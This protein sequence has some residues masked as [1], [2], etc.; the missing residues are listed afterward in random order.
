MQKRLIFIVGLIVGLVLIG[1][2]VSSRRPTIQSNKLSVVASFYPIA[3][4]A[5]QVGGDKISVTNI[6]PASTEPHDFEP[7]ARDLIRI[8]QAKLFI[9]NG[10]NVDSWGDK[11][12]SDIVARGGTVIKMSDALTSLPSSE[13]SG[14]L[15]PH[16]WLD[17]ILAQQEITVIRDR[18]VK[19]DPTNAGTYQHNAQA[20]IDQLT[21]LDQSY[22]TGLANCQLHDIVTSHAAF[23]YLA[24]R[25]G[26]TQI[27][28]AGISPDQ[29]PSP[30]KLAAIA[31]LVKQKNIHYI[32][33]ETLVSPKLSETIASETGAQTLSFNPLEGLTD[34]EIAAGKTYLTEMQTNLTHL[35]TALL[36]Q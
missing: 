28:I 1:I 16:F 20:Y 12:K 27:P 7:T 10:N 4:F 6:T 25:Y 31:H 11:V 8:S 18:L 21:A 13:E 3:H 29:E 2:L 26:F 9:Y 33:F 30:Q 36:C 19:I 35:R 23:G 22:R 24:Q 32:F 5:Q 34:Q 14:Q 17:P 15:D